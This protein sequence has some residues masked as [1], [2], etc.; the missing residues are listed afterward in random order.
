M[1]S[2]YDVKYDSGTALPDCIPKH[3]KFT[4]FCVLR[5]SVGPCYIG[6]MPPRTPARATG[7][8]DWSFRLYIS[9]GARGSRVTGIPQSEAA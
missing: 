8:H 9:L 4:S 6:A 1:D 2:E 7:L 3:D 5:P